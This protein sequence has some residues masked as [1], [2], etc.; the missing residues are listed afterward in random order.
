[1]TPTES[2][3]TDSDALDRAR[4]RAVALFISVLIGGGAFL[5]AGGFDWIPMADRVM[6][7]RVATATAGVIMICL[8]AWFAYG[9]F[10]QVPRAARARERRR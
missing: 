1:M 8:G 10:V 4:R 6:G 3:T 7:A 2:Q 5:V 9:E